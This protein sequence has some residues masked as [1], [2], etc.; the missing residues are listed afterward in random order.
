VREIHYDA[1]PYEHLS[2]QEPRLC[3]KVEQRIGQICDIFSPMLEY[4]RHHHFP[5]M[6]SIPW[7]TSTARR[8]GLCLNGT[9]IAEEAFIATF[10]GRRRAGTGSGSGSG[11]TGEINARSRSSSAPREEWLNGSQRR[12]PH[13]RTTAEGRGSKQ[14]SACPP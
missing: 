2:E 14:L 1:N 8:C 7:R 4:A 3:Q 13:P 12:V 5:R 9:E 10:K 6:S 11:A